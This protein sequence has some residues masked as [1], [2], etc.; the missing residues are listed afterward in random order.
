MIIA[1]FIVNKAGSILGFNVSG[2][3]GY[4]LNGNDIVC[5]AVSSACYMVANTIIDILNIDAKV[6]IHNNG[7][8]ILTI[9]ENDTHKCNDI[10]L[11]LKIH[12][13]ALEE[14]YPENINV[15]YTEV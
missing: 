6:N 15:N 11:G 5:A 9:D 2:H 13:I 4:N 3:S 7:K 14:Q 12:L 1:D 8:M 10:L